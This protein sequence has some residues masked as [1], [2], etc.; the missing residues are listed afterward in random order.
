MARPE[1]GSAMV[2]KEKKKGKSDRVK[3][4]KKER[5]EKEGRDSM[6]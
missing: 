2:A 1:C 4:E 5:P 6:C 3:E